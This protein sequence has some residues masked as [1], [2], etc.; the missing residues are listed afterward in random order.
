LAK[1]KKIKWPLYNTKEISRVMKSSF[2]VFKGPRCSKKEE[3][4]YGKTLFGLLMTRQD[5]LLNN[6]KACV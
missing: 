3:K 2:S 5:G 6:G 4:R 1:Q